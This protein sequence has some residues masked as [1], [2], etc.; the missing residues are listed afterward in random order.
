MVPMSTRLTHRAAIPVTPRARRAVRGSGHKALS[1]AVSTAA[2][3]A[4]AMAVVSLGLL[5]RPALAQDK[6]TVVVL[7]IQGA[8]PKLMAALEKALKGKY[9]LVPASK[10]NSA[11]TKLNATGQGA[12]E[13]CYLDISASPEGRGALLDVVAR[14][15]DRVFAAFI[16]HQLG[17]RAFSRAH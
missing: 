5:A 17:G 12:D 7:E 3:L 10:W 14:T 4:M 6:K 9:I 2:K 11:A 15:A 1:R 16:R 8:P 13:I